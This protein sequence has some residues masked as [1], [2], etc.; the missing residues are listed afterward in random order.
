MD[1]THLKYDLS[2]HKQFEELYLSTNEI[3][4]YMDEMRKKESNTLFFK[5]L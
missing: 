4:H 3:I 5:K 1:P 2:L